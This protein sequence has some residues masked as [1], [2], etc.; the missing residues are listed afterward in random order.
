MKTFV[1]GRMMIVVSCLFILLGANGI[2]AGGNGLLVVES[3][4]KTNLRRTLEFQKQQQ[5][6]G[7]R[8]TST[9][10]RRYLEESGKEK[11]EVIEDSS[12]SNET[13]EF[14]NENGVLEN[15]TEELENIEKTFDNKNEVSENETEELEN[16]EK[17]FDNENEVSENETEELEN[18]EKSFDNE[19]EVSENETEELENVEKKNGWD[20]K[21]KTGNSEEK[22]STSTAEETGTTGNEEKDQEIGKEEEKEI[23]TTSNP[24]ESPTPETK[25]STHFPVESP[26]E[27]PTAKPY[28]TTND[29]YDPITAEDEKHAE[30]EEVQELETELKQEEKVARRAGGLGIFLGIVAM[31]FTA[32]QMSENP[33]GIYAS[34]CRLAITISSVVVKIVCMPCR[35]LIGAGG[36]GNPHYN[37]HMPISTSDYSYRND[38]YR[39]NANAGFELS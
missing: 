11:E 39:S 5:L 27:K 4:R 22:Q 34:V 23:P 33:D 6:R 10:S 20:N 26:S 18:I 25:P 36:N 19:N 9:A 21:S 13:G 7:V 3:S 31:I 15:K 12:S 37:G 35:K 16:I 2:V 24:T 17:A 38:P 30:E 32:H 29:E 28:T 14:N 1:D 8:L